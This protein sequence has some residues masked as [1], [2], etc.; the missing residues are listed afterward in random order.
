MRC[1]ASDRSIY[2]NVYL[3]AWKLYSSDSNKRYSWNLTGLENILEMWI[4]VH[5]FLQFIIWFR[6]ENRL[7]MY[8][9]V[10]FV[11][12]SIEINEKV[13]ILQWLRHFFLSRICCHTRIFV[14]L[15]KIGQSFTDGIK[16]PVSLILLCYNLLK[17]NFYWHMSTL[18]TCMNNLY[19]F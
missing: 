12:C 8:N 19:V 15:L 13:L 5:H 16:T 6:S 1:R 17:M 4:H 14:A 7:N 10:H 3:W 11:D 9:I 18:C 2:V